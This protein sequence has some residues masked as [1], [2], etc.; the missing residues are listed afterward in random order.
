MESYILSIIINCENQNKD[1]IEKT[2][3]S[4]HHYEGIEVILL[5]NQ[6]ELDSSYKTIQKESLKEALEEAKRQVKGEY[7]HILSAGDYFYK[8]S[9]EKIMKELLKR[10]YTVVHCSLLDHHNLYQ[11]EKAYEQKHTKS[12]L[13]Q[14]LN[15]LPMKL[16]DAS[17]KQNIFKIYLLQI[18]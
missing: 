9:I 1:Y 11:I 8:D 15:Q 4:F 7:V 16:K 18:N 6:E 5:N 13:S 17:F 2:I 10:K 14:D 3:E 12:Y